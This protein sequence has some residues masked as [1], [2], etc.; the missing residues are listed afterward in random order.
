[1]MIPTVVHILA[2]ARFGGLE[3]VVLTLSAAQAEKGAE[4]VIVPILAQGGPH[5]FVDALEA[6]GLPVEPIVGRSALQERTAVRAMLARV[7]PDVLHCH[8]YRPDILDAPVARGLGVAT[9]STVHGFS[10]VRGK[11]KFYRMMHFRSLRDCGRVIAVSEPLRRL[12]IQGGLQ[13]RQVETLRNAWRPSQAPLGRDAARRELRISSGS[14]VLAWV[15]RMRSEKAPELAIQ[16]LAQVRN[17]DVRLMMVGAGSELDSVKRLANQL[18]VAARVDWPDFVP[19]VGRLMS[20]FDALVITSWTEGTPIVMLEAASSEVPI[21]TTAVGGI[22]DVV[23]QTEAALVDAGDVTGIAEAI[24]RLLERRGEATA[25]AQAA[26]QRVS[27]ELAVGPWVEKHSRVYR[28]A[29]T[30]T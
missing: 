23:S 30:L 4:V 17:R 3:S 10:P 21:I 22:P 13:E 18:G 2:P 24:D 9:V 11:A 25:R 20:A 19:A 14:V 29:M 12:L 6:Q 16:A 8:G 15:G 26:A 7:R 5:P 27:S 28:K 1:M